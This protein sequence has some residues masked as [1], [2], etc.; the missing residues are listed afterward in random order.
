MNCKKVFLMCYSSSGF[1]WLM[2]VVLFITSRQAAVVIILI[3]SLF[4]SRILAADGKEWRFHKMELEAHTLS[5]G[6]L[7]DNRNT[8]SSSSRIRDDPEAVQARK[9]VYVICATENK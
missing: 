1:W 2:C 8:A 5:Q 9:K 3:V 6:T 4:G 7:K